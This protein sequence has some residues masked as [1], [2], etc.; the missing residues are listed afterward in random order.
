MVSTCCSLI[1]EVRS[2]AETGAAPNVAMLKEI[3][4]LV[5]GLIRDMMHEDERTM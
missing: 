4:L 5:V 2:R 3:R 1:Y